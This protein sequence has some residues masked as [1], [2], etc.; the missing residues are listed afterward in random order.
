MIFGL[1]RMLG[2]LGRANLSRA[3]GTTVYP[4][5]EASRRGSNDPSV[6]PRSLGVARADFYRNCLWQSQSSSHFDQLEEPHGYWATD[7]GAVLSA[8]LPYRAF[9]L[10]YE[11]LLERVDFVQLFR[12]VLVVGAVALDFQSYMD[13]I[14][15]VSRGACCK[16]ADAAPDDC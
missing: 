13:R 5:S 4:A 8:D 14:L 11:K 2:D 10:I 6:L 15:A 3:T 7:V 1:T 12:E 9:E 16:A